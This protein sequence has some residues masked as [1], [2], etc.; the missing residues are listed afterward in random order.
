MPA[1]PFSGF[2][3][4]I[5]ASPKNI[6]ATYA[7]PPVTL[8]VLHHRLQRTLVNTH[9]CTAQPRIVTT[10]SWPPHFYPFHYNTHD[11]LARR[12]PRTNAMG[13]KD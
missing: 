11:L 5:D 3:S 12:L 10:V 1:E 2:S 4:C 6:Y 8:T 9:S 7:L 13:T